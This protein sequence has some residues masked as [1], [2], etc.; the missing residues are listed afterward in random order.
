MSNFAWPSYAIPA[1]FKLQRYTKTIRASSMFGGSGQNYDLM[2]DRWIVDLS[3]SIRDANNGARVEAFFNSLR[4]SVNTVEIYHMYRP[5]PLG[6]MV[7]SPL[8][9]GLNE[10]GAASIVLQAAANETLRSGDMIGVSGLLLQVAF[11]CQANGSGVIT[12][13]IIG[14]LNKDI[15]ANSPVTLQKPTSK[16]HLTGKGTVSYG[17]GGHMQ[18]ASFSFAESIGRV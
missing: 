8:T 16:F 11:D 14:R 12:V 7:S 1:S 9:S 10:Q 15:V 18:Q 5:K 2:N 13:P 6:T 17:R 3:I 4:G